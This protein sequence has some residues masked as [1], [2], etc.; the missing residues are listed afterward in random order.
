MDLPNSGAGGPLRKA[1]TGNT[2]HNKG[3]RPV[4]HVL[5]AVPLEWL[6]D[7]STD[8]NTVE[9]G[10]RAGATYVVIDNNGDYRI[11]TATGEERDDPWSLSIV[12]APLDGRPYYHVN[13]DWS[14]VSY[15]GGTIEEVDGLQ[16]AVTG[17]G[18]K[19]L[20]P[21]LATYVPYTYTISTLR[22]GAVEDNG[23]GTILILKSGYYGIDVYLDVS[24][25]ANSAHI[26]GTTYI[27]N[28]VTGDRIIARAN[29]GRVPNI[30]DIANLSGNGFIWLEAGERVT[31]AVGSDV[32]GTITIH[33][34][35]LQLTYMGV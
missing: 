3:Q 19:N 31:S 6:T 28:D 12:S 23:D 18:D 4:P 11:A 15:A 10:K 33:V 21:T 32:T 24:H 5:T 34:S 25:S 2:E 8:Y 7:P 30:G 9:N 29:H 27:Y 1:V 14:V 17:T 20:V 22:D 26:G 13:G 35:H 16:V